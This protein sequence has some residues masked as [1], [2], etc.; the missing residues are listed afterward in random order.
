[1]IDPQDGLEGRTLD[2]QILVGKTIAT[3][4]VVGHDPTCDGENVLRLVCTD[5]TSIDV[6]GGYGG[7]TGESCDEYFELITVDL[8]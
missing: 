3:A 7:Y 2:A 1:M 5:G 8:T 4:E 6:F